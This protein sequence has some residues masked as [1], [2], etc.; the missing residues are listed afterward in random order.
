MAKHS[1]SKPPDPDQLFILFNEIGIVNQLS[2]N[3]FERALP[4]GLTQ[5]QFSVLN[6][7]VRLGGSR[8]P[9]QLAD[10]FQVTKGAMT[11]TLDKLAKKGAIKISPDP[12]DGRAK[13]VTLTPR[14]RK[15]RERAIA[16]AGPAFKDVADVIAA[17][18]VEQVIPFLQKLRAFLDTHRD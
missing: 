11:N 16:A 7:F 12:N 2:T 9:K 3:R 4:D 8:S 15:M 10:A 1:T 14:G 13:I 17:E 5:S 18:D 6:N